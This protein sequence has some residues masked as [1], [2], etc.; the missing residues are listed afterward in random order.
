MADGVALVATAMNGIVVG[1]VHASSSG[2]F[3]FSHVLTDVT[4]AV[5]PDY[6]RQGIARSLF[7]SFFAEI[8][9]RLP[10]ISRVE[11]ISRESNTAAIHFYEQLGFVRE[12]RLEGRIKNMDGSFEADIPMG[13][14]RTSPT[15]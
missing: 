10:H 11:L 9:K 7:E 1:E 5:D 13:W 14:N 8:A 3:C 6:R 4:V 15:R 2:L 12:G